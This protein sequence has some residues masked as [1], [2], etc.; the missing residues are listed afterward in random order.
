MENFTN[1]KSTLNVSQAE[2]I[3]HLS[4]ANKVIKF[5]ERMQKPCWIILG[6]YWR[7]WGGGG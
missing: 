2:K 7:I 4:E 5:F 1:E 3:V 6:W